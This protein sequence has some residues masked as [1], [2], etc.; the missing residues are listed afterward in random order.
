MPFWWAKAIWSARV[1]KAHGK[2]GSPDP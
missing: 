2:P 1:R